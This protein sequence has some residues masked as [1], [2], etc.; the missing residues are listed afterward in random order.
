MSERTLFAF[1]Y[2]NLPV[3]GD[4]SSA[5]TI[6]HELGE[7]LTGDSIYSTIYNPI[8]GKNLTGTYCQ[9]ACKKTIGKEYDYT[10]YKWLIEQQY[11]AY[12]F[13]DALP[14]GLNMGYIGDPSRI[15]VIQHEGGIPIGEKVTSADETL[16]KVY[17]HLT[18]IISLHKSH[19]QG[20]GLYYVVE[21]NIMPFR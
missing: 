15:N 6:H 18:F 14:A 8:I 12:F 5:Q 9:Y 7:I 10:L 17:N 3:C 19:T 11:K 2:Y 21:F 4:R 16:Y 13:A 1:N 20:E